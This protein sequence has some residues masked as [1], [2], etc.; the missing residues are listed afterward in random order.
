M[1]SQRSAGGPQ[2]IVL[3]GLPASLVCRFD[4][5]LHRRLA[6]SLSVEQSLFKTTPR[7]SL[8]CHWLALKRLLATRRPVHLKSGDIGEAT[9]ALNA[10]FSVAEARRLANRPSSKKAAKRGYGYAGSSQN[11]LPTLTSAWP[12]F[13]VSSEGVARMLSR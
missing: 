1:S 9:R 13:A 5:A 3:R 11:L 6:V 7:L 8:A 10:Y 12:S 2:V 4:S